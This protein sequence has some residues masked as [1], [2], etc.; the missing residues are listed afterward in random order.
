METTKILTDFYNSFKDYKTLDGSLNIN[1]T[2]SNFDLIKWVD[3]LRD[4]LYKD[5]FALAEHV[6]D[7]IEDIIPYMEFKYS[8]QYL[9]T[10]LIKEKE[11]MTFRDQ[12]NA[13]Q[14]DYYELQTMF[15]FIFSLLNRL[16]MLHY[17]S[18]N[19]DYF[20]NLILEEQEKN[21]E[22][23]N[24]DAILMQKLKRVTFNN[25]RYNTKITQYENSF[26]WSQF[27]KNARNVDEHYGVLF[28]IEDPQRFKEST[29]NFYIEI[30]LSV[31][32]FLYYLDDYKAE[33]EQNGGGEDFFL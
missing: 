17:I 22:H 27:L 20:Y 13:T 32:L 21:P 2:N 14:A 24:V 30:M 16:T 28:K 5:D 33:F 23:P 12:V 31:Y 25:W 7:K 11:H 6:M 26:L 1:P 29:F 8:W 3:D 19:E 4:E 9:R 15:T 10:E 18:T